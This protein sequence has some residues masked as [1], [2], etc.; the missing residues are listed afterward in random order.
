MFAE[1]QSYNLVEAT[2]VPSERFTA[3]IKQV[4]DE[5][6]PDRSLIDPITQFQYVE[7]DEYQYR[8]GLESLVRF[9]RGRGVT[10]VA[11]RTVGRGSVC[12]STHADFESLSDGVVSLTLEGS[13]RRLS[14]PKHR[15]LGQTDGESRG[16][17]TALQHGNGL[18]LWIA[19]WTVSLFGGELSIEDNSPRGTRVV[20][21]L[22][23]D[24]GGAV[25][26]MATAD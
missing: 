2:G 19:Y 23:R 21:R 25:P 9:L 10:T 20:L 8:K 22:P 4:I 1:D 12:S 15:G 3:D 5:V 11:T 6:D 13:E 7:Q 17:E 26:Q 18:G 24:S 16:D 14:V